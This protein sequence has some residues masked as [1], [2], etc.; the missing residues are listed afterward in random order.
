[1]NCCKICHFCYNRHLS[2]WPF[3]SSLCKYLLAK[4]AI[5]AK[6]VMVL[7]VNMPFFVISFEYLAKPLMN[8][9]PAPP[10]RHFCWNLP[11][12]NISLLVTHLICGF[13]RP[14]M[15]SWPIPHFL[16]FAIFEKI[17]TV[18]MLVL[19]FHLNFLPDL[20]WILCQIRKIC[21]FRK[22]HNYRH[23]S[24]VILLKFL[25]NLSCL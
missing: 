12:V 21:H 17:A 14:L 22:T 1:M 18:I 19:L 2:R 13:A 11:L 5:F 25:P 9:W 8:F 6:F 3:L 7:I 24:F 10:P 15:D 16:K 4:F 23:A 20:Q